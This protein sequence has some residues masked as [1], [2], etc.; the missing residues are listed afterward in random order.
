MNKD[1]FF[2]SNWKM[3]L[4]LDETFNFASTNY[5]RFTKLANK[6]FTKIILCPSFVSLYTLIKIFKN[7]KIKIGAQDC[8]KHTKGPFTGQICAQS[9]KQLG[10]S[11][12]IIGHSETRTEQK[13][14]IQDIVKKYEQL[15]KYNISPIICIGENIKEYKTKKTLTKID[16][17]LNY[18]FNIINKEVI[19]NVFIAYEPLWAIGTGNI[20]T[21]DELETVFAY[22]HKKTQKLHSKINWKFL[23]GGSISSKNIQIFK[24]IHNLDGFL[25]GKASLDI[26]ALEKIVQLY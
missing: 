17:E 15:M 12:C 20:P 25:M 23:Y 10:C 26:Q 22:L 13:Y 24:K 14:T 1:L 5:D 21:Q 9:I 16:N 4:T 6:E 11:H 18:F 19:T 8:S 3:N 2:I 7:T